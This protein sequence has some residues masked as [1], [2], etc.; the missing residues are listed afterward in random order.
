MKLRRVRIENFRQILYWEHEFTDSLQRVRDV[1]L[2]V[3]PNASGKTSILDAI[4]AAINPLTRINALRPG[5]EMS[6][7]RIVRHGATF[8][9]VEAEVEFSPAEID[10]A[11]AVLD[12]LEHKEG[13]EEAIR[14]SKIVSF[15]WTFPDPSEKYAYGRTECQPRLGWSIFRS[16]SRVAQLLATQ[17][18][19]NTN[20]L[21][22]AGA[23]FTFDQQRSLFGRLI[24]RAIWDVLA[25]SG[26]LP[27]LPPKLT[28]ES[29]SEQDRR[30]TDPRLLLLSMAIQ[31]LLPPSRSTTQAEPSDFARVREAYARIC[32]PHSITGAVRDDIERFDIEFYNGSTPYEYADLSS[33]EQMVLLILIRMASE[34]I[35]SSILL[36]D[37]VELHQH[38]IWQRRLL[39]DLR[40]VGVN[41]QIIATTHSNYLRD[42]LP[43]A[44][45]VTLGDIGDSKRKGG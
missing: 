20:L 3:G 2:L 29:P 14:E 38:P 19:R 31:E 32:H 25:N 12:M 39:D 24:P 35:H 27:E 26:S 7:K 5:L 23:V 45:V 8:A 16:R 28:V 6:R 21:E 9:R 10:T 17:R 41:N 22:S 36:V 30:T 44:H 34:R 43:P 1:T 37:E 4:A 11:L 40:Q 15:S 18:L 13:E 42:V 33:G